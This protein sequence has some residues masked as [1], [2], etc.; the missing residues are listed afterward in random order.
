M[1]NFALLGSL[2]QSLHQ[3]FVNW[4]YLLLPV[5]FALALAFDWFRNPA[6]S[7]DFLDTLKRAIIATLLLV[8]Y[9]E[10]ANAILSITT[11]IADKISDMSGL[12][13]ILKMAGEKTKNY[14]LTPMSL[15]LGFNDLMVAVLTFASYVVLYFARIISVAIFQ[16][17]WLFLSIASPLLILFNL[18]RGTAHITVNLFKSLVEVA[19]YKIVWAILSA[20]L[21]SLSFG[22][23][24]ATDGNYL[25]VIVLNFVI[26]LAMLGTPKIVKSLVGGGLA[27]MSESLGIAAT[28]AMAA[29]PAKAA[30]AIEMGREVLSDTRGYGNH[31]LE[32]AYGPKPYVPPRDY[33]SQSSPSNASTRSHSDPNSN[34]RSSGSQ[35]IQPSVA[36]ASTKPNSTNVPEQ[37]TS[38]TAPPVQSQTAVGEPNKKDD[39]GENKL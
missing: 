30:A 22:N 1:E 23:A 35:Q 12:D 7:P 34:Q 27:G 14:T 37:T 16:F 19:S 25:T 38:H 36:T 28:V 32:K 15:V 17:M 31:L 2:A 4:F 20:M 9:Q 13:T 21:T 39:K 3:E 10:I 8:A 33:G 18:F 26:A 24:Y 6:G 11:G 29:A 5:F